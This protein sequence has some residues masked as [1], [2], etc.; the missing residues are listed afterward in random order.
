MKSMCNYIICLL[1]GLY[2]IERIQ[3][4]EKYYLRAISKGDVIAIYSY[5]L[6]LYEGLYG[7]HK[8]LN[9]KNII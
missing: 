7:E 4:S 8:K 5:A 6:K 9:Q 3:G 2:S 1:K